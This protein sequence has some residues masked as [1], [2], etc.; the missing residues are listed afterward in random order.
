M[1]V[2]K[3][4]D[5]LFFSTERTNVTDRQTPHDGIRHAYA[6]HIARQKLDIYINRIKAKVYKYF[7][8]ACCRARTYRESFVGLWYDV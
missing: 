7:D 8:V 5:M 1:V 6:W 2:K 3:I 4:E